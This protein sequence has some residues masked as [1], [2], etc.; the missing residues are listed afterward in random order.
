M[1]RVGL[2]PTRV[3]PADFKSAAFADFAIAPV[4]YIVPQR[5]RASSF[6]RGRN[7]QVSHLRGCETWYQ[8]HRFGF[9]H[10]IEVLM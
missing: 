10:S 7:Y 3:S 4:M 2:E 9:S 5:S 8:I 6:R 1:G